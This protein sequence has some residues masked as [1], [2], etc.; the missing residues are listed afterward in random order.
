MEMQDASPKLC[1]SMKLFKPQ[2]QLMIY[3]DSSQ[4]APER[5]SL[6]QYY[7]C[8]GGQLWELQSHK[9]KLSAWF[10]LSTGKKFPL[11]ISEAACPNTWSCRQLHRGAHRH[12]CSWCV[13]PTQ[14]S[15]ETH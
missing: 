11:Q 4:T 10:C 9:A 15:L 2:Q 8:R 7:P 5:I 1:I 13:F 12:T 3:F 14:N 6:F